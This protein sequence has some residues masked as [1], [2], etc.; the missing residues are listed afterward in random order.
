MACEIAL[1]DFGL[2]NSIAVD[3]MLEAE[4]GVGEEVENLQKQRECFYIF[5]FQNVSF[6]LKKYV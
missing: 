3:G 2:N 1:G 4:L 6:F 5:F